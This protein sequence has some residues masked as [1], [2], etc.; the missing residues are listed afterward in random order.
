[1]DRTL[2][3][4]LFLWCTVAGTLVKMWPLD[5]LAARVFVPYLM[6]VSVVD[7]LSFSPIRRNSDRALAT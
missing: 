2:F 7:M 1:M 5:R 3:V 4:G 6:W